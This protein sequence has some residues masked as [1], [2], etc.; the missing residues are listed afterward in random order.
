VIS[1]FRVLG[2]PLFRQENGERMGHG[3]IELNDINRRMDTGATVGPASC[4]D[5]WVGRGWGPFYALV[6]A[7]DSLADVR[8]AGAAG[9]ALDRAV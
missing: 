2:F 9:S 3:G 1:H 5:L 8:R 6:A 4:G 7:I